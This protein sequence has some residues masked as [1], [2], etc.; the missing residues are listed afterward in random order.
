MIRLK[1]ISVIFFLR[2]LFLPHYLITNDDPINFEYGKGKRLFCWIF[3]KSS[4]FI[5]IGQSWYSV[6]IHYY[7]CVPKWRKKN[8]QQKKSI[9]DYND[10]DDDDCD[11]WILF[12]FSS[13]CC[14]KYM[15]LTFI[16][17]Q[18]KQNSWILFFFLSIVVVVVVVVVN[19]F[20]IIITNK[21]LCAAVAVAAIKYDDDVE[22]LILDSTF[23][24]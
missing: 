12:Y 19:N 22:I 21:N 10:D 8:T 11:P 23:E 15:S 1:K 2:I 9:I 17:C 7:I 13:R 20:W 6:H 18:K 16:G 4:L 3:F 24:S 5:I 14:T